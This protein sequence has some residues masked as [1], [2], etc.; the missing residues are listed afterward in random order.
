MLKV[1]F[2]ANHHWLK[3]KHQQRGPSAQASCRRVPSALRHPCIPH[4]FRLSTAEGPNRLPKSAHMV[5]RRSTSSWEKAA[6]ISE[7]TSNTAMTSP[8][9]A[10]TGTTT[11]LFVLLLQAMCSGRTWTSGTSCV[12]LVR[13]AAP[14]I[15]F[16]KGMSRHPWPP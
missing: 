16:S 14:Q 8:F 9:G 3:F 1:S 7:S 10:M 5:S 6:G 12:C 13:A 4:A 2:Q 15:P 11:S